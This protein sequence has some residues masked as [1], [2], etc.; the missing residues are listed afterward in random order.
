M[1]RPNIYL[2]Y[3]ASTQSLVNSDGTN[4]NVVVPSLYIHNEYMILIQIYDDYPTVQDLSTLSTW[5]NG[6]G[7]V[8]GLTDP[9]LVETLDADINTDPWA[10]SALG[11]ISIIANT[12]ATALVTAMGT[13]DTKQYKSELKGWDG[14]NYVTIALLPVYARNTVYED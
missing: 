7:L 9:P 4:S 3:D 1:F 14:T 2:W 12:H 5:K 10:N 8:G 11:K 6:I 13:S